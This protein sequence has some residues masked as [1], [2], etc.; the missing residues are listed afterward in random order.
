MNAATTR[1]TLF[2]STRFNVLILIT[3]FT[4]F[5]Q[6]LLLPLLT[7]LVDRTGVGSGINGLN[8][9]AMYVGTFSAM[10]LVERPFRRF[11]YKPVI[12]T[13]LLMILI[14]VLL[15][16]LWTNLWFWVVLRIF[17]GIGESSLHFCTQLWIMASSPIDKRGRSISLYG[18]SYAVGF[19]IGPLGI[20]LLN[21]GTGSPFLL[22]AAFVLACVLLLAK[23]N[24]ERPEASEQP[25]ASEADNMAE[26]TSKPR[27]RYLRAYRI[28]WFA[29]LPSLLFGY[30]ESSLNSNFPV[31]GLKLGFSESWITI[32]LPA[33]GIGSLILQLP[34]GALSDKLGRKRVLIFAG[35]L[36]SLAFLAIPS[37]GTNPWLV[38]ALLA[39]AGGMVGS[40]FS[41]GL[42]Y[43]ADLV[44]ASLLASAN[45][46][47]SIQYSAGSIIGPNIGGFS[48]QY[49][50]LSA[51]FYF[52]GGSYLLFSLL[53]IGFRKEKER[54]ERKETISVIHE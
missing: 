36:G 8:A 30:M 2:S 46:I 15:F 31:Y 21:K 38:L 47:A 44:P 17:V 6:G 3:V 11:G 18:L 35:L 28:A 52:M 9:A 5:S 48:M 42:A 4:G 24:N 23:V 37:A 34:L 12:Q 19:S 32:L 26:G 40:F 22:I 10:F 14:G 41:L 43:V 51:M 13:G 16:P 27:N 1:S 54:V 20:N 25:V 53:G 33:L 49:V 29:L 45:V 50:S 39:F 7:I